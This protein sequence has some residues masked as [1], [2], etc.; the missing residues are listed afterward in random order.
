VTAGRLSEPA[1][2]G[3]EIADLEVLLAELHGLE[4]GLEA[5][6]NGSLEGDRDLRAI[7]DEAE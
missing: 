1:R 2:Q 5:R 4:A 6:L 3:E 7:R